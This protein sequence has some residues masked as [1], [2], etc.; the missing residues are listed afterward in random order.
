L[1]L[2]PDTDAEGA[3]VLAERIRDTV[4][5][6]Q[7]P[8]VGNVTISLG[9]APWKKGDSRNTMINRADR[10]MYLAK[11]NGRNRVEGGSRENLG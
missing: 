7:F 2:A 6:H 9:V 8:G 1:I 5:W 10:Y 4:A 11:Q 3:R